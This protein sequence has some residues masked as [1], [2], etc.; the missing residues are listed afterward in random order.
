MKWEAATGLSVILPS[1]CP[2][3]SCSC[4][5]PTPKVLPDL[6][7][8]SQDW[9]NWDRCRSR[10]R[11]LDVAVRRS[12]RGSRSM[13]LIS[14]IDYGF[15][16][17]DKIGGM[18]AIT[19]PTTGRCDQRPGRAWCGGA[20]LIRRRLGGLKP[21][22]GTG[23]AGRSPRFFEIEKASAKRCSATQ[24][25][26]GTQQRRPV[27]CCRESLSKS[28][29]PPGF[30][31]NGEKGA[32]KRGSALLVSGRGVAAVF[33]TLQAQATSRATRLSCTQL[34]GVPIPAMCAW[35]GPAPAGRPQVAK[36]FSPRVDACPALTPLPGALR[37]LLRAAPGGLRLACACCGGGRFACGALLLAAPAA[38]AAPCRPGATKHKYIEIRKPQQLAV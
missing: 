26:I 18:L 33:R 10:P 1:V 15:P 13:N 31:I 12:H 32:P 11:A 7:G 17:V 16:G 19:V 27:N 2:A 5:E 36:L 35:R 4:S 9:V 38:G 29:L 6:D 24:C 23:L 37:L 21:G 3:P 30:E 22:G 20:C 25:R 28:L 8:D 34:L 14:G